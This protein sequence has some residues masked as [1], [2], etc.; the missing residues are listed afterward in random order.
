MHNTNRMEKKNALKS[1]CE[2]GTSAISCVK[3]MYGGMLYGFGWCD[4]IRVLCYWLR[5]SCL[6][7][8]AAPLKIKALHTV[9]TIHTQRAQGT[10]WETVRE[11]CHSVYKSLAQS[12]KSLRAAYTFLEEKS[13]SVNNNSNK[14]NGNNNNNKIYACDV[15]STITGWKKAAVNKWTT[16][17]AYMRA[18]E[19]SEYERAHTNNRAGVKRRCAGTH[20]KQDTK[21]RIE[22]ERGKYTREK[23]EEWKNGRANAN[24]HTN[25]MTLKKCIALIIIIA[26]RS[27]SIFLFFAYVW[28][29]K[30]R[31]G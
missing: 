24:R 4:G 12:G 19:Q 9:R 8:Y 2:N 18:R 22:E 11:I 17:T 10:E 28:I 1:K 20:K 31:N 15:N 25:G 23:N 29:L 13:A 21:K 14:C 16:V 26:L 7:R 30:A 3:N 5:T 6:S 27:D